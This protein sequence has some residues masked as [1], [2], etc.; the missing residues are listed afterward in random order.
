MET[1][2]T[3]NAGDVSAATLSKVLAKKLRNLKQEFRMIKAKFESG[4]ARTMRISVKPRGPRG[5]TGPPG[6]IGPQG[7]TG[8]AGGRGA[9][10]PKGRR[11]PMGPPGPQGR[12][13]KTGPTGSIGKAGAKGATGRR[14]A[15]GPRGF[16]GPPGARGLPGAA[17]AP[18][19]NG[20][21]GVPGPQGENSPEGPI[22]PPGNA[23]APGKAGSPGIN[24]EGGPPGKKG[25]TGKNGAVGAPGAVGLA[26]AD[27]VGPPKS[28][29]PVAKKTKLGPCYVRSVSCGKYNIAENLCGVC[30]GAD[31]RKCASEGGWCTCEGQV[32]FGSGDHWSQESTSKGQIYC[33]ADKFDRDPAPGKTKECQC[34]H[35]FKLTNSKGLQF[36][37]KSWDDNNYGAGSFQAR[38]VCLLARYGN[39]FVNKETKCANQ[40]ASCTC[41]G[42]V[43]FGVDSSWSPPVRV[44]D[45]IMCAAGKDFKDPAPSKAK[46]CMC[47]AAAFPHYPTTESF[48]EPASDPHA[49]KAPHFFGN[50]NDDNSNSY[51]QNQ[52][53]CTNSRLLPAGRDWS[54]MVTGNSCSGDEDTDTMWGSLT[55]YGTSNVDASKASSAPPPPPA[56]KKDAFP[57]KLS[58]LL[59]DNNPKKA[60]LNSHCASWRDK[61]GQKSFAWQAKTMAKCMAQDCEQSL[62]K[63]NGCRFMDDDRL[64][65]AY[66]SAQLWC[67]QDPTN[68]YC[69]DQGATWA[70]RP[71]G[72]AKDAV[73]TKWQ[74]RQ[75]VA[76]ANPLASDPKTFNCGCFKDCTC[77][78]STCDC[79]SKTPTTVGDKAQTK[80]A[81]GK[82]FSINEVKSTG[83]VGKCW[84]S[85]HWQTSS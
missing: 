68:K 16:T 27:G 48:A 79:A 72:T 47:S 4:P 28:L 54:K 15:T 71:Y 57:T 50:C 85:C 60:I 76:V 39:M 23:G 21:D 33:A 62:K 73:S 82:S 11:G 19:A 65:Y 81:N 36:A 29:L 5:F 42:N 43:R 63:N 53:C 10:G 64:C 78:G 41:D 66:S 12:K 46:V 45:S 26:G 58:G 37:G 34:A 38:N 52:N 31:W 9:P 6:P 59:R 30:E 32:R 61:Q 17:G 69:H 70:Q 3:E 14:G 22:G 20:A 1:A 35:G 51:K 55:C 8:Q 25:R 75:D 80:T 84:C 44:H 49:K 56:R 77:T 67:A 83:A 40:G 2:E 13:G 7:D 74:P 24:G 18:G